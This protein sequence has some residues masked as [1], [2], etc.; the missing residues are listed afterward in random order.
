MS[1]AV[2]RQP[3]GAPLQLQVTG[4]G[5]QGG[6]RPR[7]E[8]VRHEH[9]PAGA[10]WF[11]CDRRWGVAGGRRVVASSAGHRSRVPAIVPGPFYD[12]DVHLK[13]RTVRRPGGGGRAT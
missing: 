4:A 10:P 3:Q 9:A 12:V 13:G 7:A 6:Y 5:V 11:F 8:R 2:E 1:L